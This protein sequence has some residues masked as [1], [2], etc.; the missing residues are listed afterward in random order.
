MAT[1]YTRREATQLPQIPLQR[2]A[3]TRPTWPITSS[4]TPANPTSTY[5]PLTNYVT[6]AGAFT[7]RASAYGT[8]DQSGLVYEWYDLE[9]TTATH[10]GLRGGI[11]SAPASRQSRPHYLGRRLSEKAMT[12]AF[13]W[14]TRWWNQPSEPGAI[15]RST[16]GTSSCPV[17]APCRRGRLQRRTPG[18]DRPASG[19]RA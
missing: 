8:L 13:A 2:V 6:A 11:G 5:D 16:A 3:A 7:N 15:S 1:S 19:H 9:G 14:Q 17:A 12:Q 10:R 18:W 4:S